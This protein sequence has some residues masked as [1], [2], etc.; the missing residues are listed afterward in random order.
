MESRHAG[1]D[2]ASPASRRRVVRS[3]PGSDASVPLWMVAVLAGTLAQLPLTAPAQAEPSRDAETSTKADDPSSEVIVVTGRSGSSGL[4]PE[5]ERAAAL[6]TVDLDA[7]AELASDFGSVLRRTRGISLRQSGGLGS[8]TSF[9]LNG[10]SGRQIPIFLDGLPIELSGFASNV[11]AIP[12]GLI[13]QLE[14]YKGVVPI[15]L[16]SDALGGALNLRTRETFRSRAFASYEH[17][18]FGTHRLLGDVLVAEDSYLVT[19]Q[20]WF[21][22]ARNDY[23]IVVDGF[24]LLTGQVQEDSLEVEKNNAEFQSFGLSGGFGLRGLSW[25]DELSFR[26]FYGD[27]RKGL[28]HDLTQTVAYGEVETG[29]ASVGGVARHRMSL[30]PWIETHLALGFVR[31]DARLSDLADTR[32]DFEG[33]PR[34]QTRGELVSGGIE[35]DLTEWL[36]TARLTVDVA[37]AQEHRVVLSAAPELETRDGSRLQPGSGEG[38]RSLPGFQIFSMVAGLS[39]RFEPRL[40]PVENDLFMKLYV[41]DASGED[42]VLGFSTGEVDQSRVDFGIGDA[43]RWTIL[44]FLSLRASGEWATRLPDFSEV[45]G[46]G[47]LVSGNGELEPERSINLNL[48]L[49][50]FGDSSQ[51]GRFEATAWG[52]ARIVDDLI[53]IQTGSSG[54]RF[55]NI[56]SALVFGGE[57][58]ALW[59]S[60]GDYLELSGV[61]TYEEGRNTSFEGA[62]ARFRDDRLPNRPYLYG[63]GSLRG[64]LDGLFAAGDRL[65][66]LGRARWVHEFFLLWP[67]AGDP[68]T[69][70]V[71]PE[72]LVVDVG[73]L[74][75]FSFPLRGPE[76]QM[77]LSLESRNVLDGRVFDLLGVELPGRSFHLKLTG[78]VE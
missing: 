61:L 50:A 26:A 31:R 56:D 8:R 11:A 28:P 76:S 23:T 15:E 22:E 78:S 46:D 16:A 65:E 48:S 24:D 52:F 67:S 27:S 45:F 77:T 68:S 19:A 42:V 44:D 40:L 66:A 69:K 55:V 37:A 33:N 43:V 7:E 71:I 39:Y 35:Q 59:R 3:L 38:P 1:A 75:R 70:A 21:D 53:L 9:S 41:F 18:S 54:S 30:G 47:V 58:E 17:G 5:V 32:Y 13:G 4:S 57:A 63:S 25:A 74:Y 29:Q 72:Q 14:I 2:E 20:V 34:G 73:L 36:A 12:V 10:L 51:L 62:F 6:D 64:G 60:P 49:S